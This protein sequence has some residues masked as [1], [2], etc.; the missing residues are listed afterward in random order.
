[1]VYCAGECTLHMVPWLVL[2][3]VTDTVPVVLA[4]ARA[5]GPR[6]AQLIRYYLAGPPRPSLLDVVAYCS[7]DLRL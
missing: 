3:A 4:V 2:R 1:M 7:S 5:V 6:K